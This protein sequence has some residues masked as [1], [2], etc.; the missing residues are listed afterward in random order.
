MA[1][2][3]E[4]ELVELITLTTNFPE[5]SAVVFKTIF[6]TNEKGDET[7]NMDEN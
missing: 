5:R 1:F 2:E 7:Q 6:T 4:Q 3:L